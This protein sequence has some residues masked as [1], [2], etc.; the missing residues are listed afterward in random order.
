[1][2]ANHRLAWTI[3]V[4]D[5]ATERLIEEHELNSVTVERLREIFHQPPDAPMVDSFRLDEAQAKELEPYLGTPLRLAAG[6]SYFLECHSS[7]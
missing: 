2:S 6:R 1:M 5:D 7:E 3:D 4:F